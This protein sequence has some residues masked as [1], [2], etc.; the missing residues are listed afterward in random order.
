MKEIV[1][2]GGGGQGRETLGL[3]QSINRE[4]KRWEIKGFYDDQIPVGSFIHGLPVLGSVDDLSQQKMHINVAL[5]IGNS[6]VRRRVYHKLT[7]EYLSFPALISPHALLLDRESI[8]F[9][10]GVICCAG[11]IITCDV[12][13]GSFTLLNLACTVGHDAVI[14]PFCSFMHAV[15]IAGETLIKEGVYMGTNSSVINRVTIGANSTIGAG[16]VVIRDIPD[17]CVAVGCPA[18]PIRH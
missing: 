12:S 17:N 4:T 13:I 15:N 14:E 16:A 3:I 2:V 7:N 9:G 5:A 1:I 11:T 18:K 10:E 8:S 6:S